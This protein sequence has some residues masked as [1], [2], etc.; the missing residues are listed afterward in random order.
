MMKHKSLA[1]GLAMAAVGAVAWACGPDFPTQMLDDRAATLNVVP[2]NTFAFEASHLLPATDGL[3]AVE[4]DPYDDAAKVRPDLTPE[5]A[6][7]VKTLAASESGAKAFDAGSDLPPDVRAYAAGAVDWKLAIAACPGAPESQYGE[8]L[9]KPPCA[10]FDAAALDAAQARFEQVLALSPD[11]AP[12]RGAWAAYMLGE[13][14]AL[15][16]AKAAGTPAFA[17]HRDAAAKAFQQARTRVLAGASDAQGLAVASFGEEARLSLYADGK[18]C[19]WVDL[20]NTASCTQ[21]LSPADLKHAIALYS[22]QAGHG[23]AN[24]VQSLASI[25]SAVLANDDQVAALIDGPVSQRLLVVYAI[26]SFSAGDPDGNQVAV[27]GVVDAIRAAGPGKVAAGDRLASLLYSMGRYD[28][29]EAVLT[30]ADGPLASWVRAKLALRKGDREGAA[31]FYAEAAKAFPK[32]DDPTAALGRDSAHRLV[33]ESGVLA[34]ARGEYVEAMARM[35]QVA[36]SVGGDGNGYERDLGDQDAGYGNN[37]SSDSGTG[38]GNDMNYIAERVLTVDEL[39]TFVDANVPASLPAATPQKA[40]S[41]DP[42]ELNDRLRWLLA[43]RLM[44]VGRFDDAY[45]Y[46]PSGATRQSFPPEPEL[47]SDPDSGAP[48]HPADID[49][50]A[51]AKAYANAVHDGDTAWTGIGKAEARYAAA[52]IAREQGM[53]LLGYEQGPDYGDNGGMYQGGSGQSAE[54]LK[55]DL[56]TAGERQ[57]FNDSAAQPDRRYHYRYL[58]ADRA[59]SAAELLPPRSQAFAAT[60]CKAT[61][62]MLEGPPD[63]NEASDGDTTKP[64]NERQRRVRAYYARYVK[65]GPYVAWAADFGRSCEEPDFA[66]ARKLKRAEQV[67]AVK[68]FVRKYL[69]VEIAVLVLVVAGLVVIFRRR[70]RRQT[71]R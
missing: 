66:G 29:A 59:V 68:H 13:V 36:S 27:T 18:P 34:L 15:R 21:A 9:S 16:A 48:S 26:A 49:L 7:R 17:S 22:A 57:R 10:V 23:S 38:F 70:R 52:K 54:T 40:A 3:Q 47:Y 11:Q 20:Y 12:R 61:N 60:L 42:L 44:R 55:G 25:A 31:R 64:L 69:A 62:W 63:Y 33:G 30:K 58:A 37:G 8:S 5:Q 46:F 4:S 6:E 67:R 32:A 43:R 56:V 41:T 14:H 50:R 45:A 39:K 19:V 1:I 35:Y 51:T 28:E 2:Q 65:K 24:A 53:E 71:A